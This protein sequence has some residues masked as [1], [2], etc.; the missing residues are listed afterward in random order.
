MFFLGIIVG[1]AIGFSVQAFFKQYKIVERNKEWYM[2]PEVFIEYIMRIIFVAPLMILCYLIFRL[3]L[4]V[5][6]KDEK[7]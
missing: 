2:L 7:V 4:V 6:E 5:I 1:I 3:S